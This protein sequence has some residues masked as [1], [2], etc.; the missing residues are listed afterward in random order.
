MTRRRTPAES[1]SQSTGEERKKENKQKIGI[2]TREVTSRPR[3]LMDFGG[4]SDDQ[5][6]N[7]TIECQTRQPVSRYVLSVTGYGEEWQ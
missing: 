6:E 2:A 5:E 1:N 3:R 4:R 7:N